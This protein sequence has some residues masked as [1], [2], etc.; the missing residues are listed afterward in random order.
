MLGA[1]AP[2]EKV[3]EVVIIGVWEKNMGVD[4]RKVR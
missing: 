3:S 2:W 4:A 1:K